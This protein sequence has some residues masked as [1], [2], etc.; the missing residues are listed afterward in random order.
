[1]LHCIVLYCIVLCCIVLFCVA[2]YCF[3]LHCFVLHC[4]VLCCIVLFCI[5]LF[6]VALYCFVLHC[7][8]LRCI[9]LICVAFYCAAL[10]CIALFCVALHCFVLHSIVLHCIALHCFVLHCILCC[11]VLHCIVLHCIVLC[12]IALR[13]IVSHCIVLHCIGLC[14]IV[15]HRRNPSLTFTDPGFWGRGRLVSQKVDADEAPVAVATTPVWAPAHLTPLPRA[16]RAAAARLGH[17]TPRTHPFVHRTLHLRT[18]DTIWRRGHHWRHKQIRKIRF[19]YSAPTRSTTQ[20][21]VTVLPVLVHNTN[22][23]TATT[24]LYCTVYFFPVCVCVCWR[25]EYIDSHLQNARRATSPASGRVS[26]TQVRL[27]SHRPTSV[28]PHSC[29]GPRLICSCLSA[30]QHSPN[31]NHGRAQAVRMAAH[32][33][34]CKLPERFGKFRNN[35]SRTATLQLPFSCCQ[36]PWPT[37]SA[38]SLFKNHT[39][40]LPL[41]FSSFTLCSQHPTPLPN[42]PPPP[43]HPTPNAVAPPS[44]GGGWGG[45]SVGKEG[46]LGGG[47]GGGGGVELRTQAADTTAKGG[48]TQSCSVWLA[49]VHTHTHSATHTYKHRQT[50]THTHTLS[51]QTYPLSHTHTHTHSATHT[52]TR[53]P[54]PHKHTLSLTHTHTHTQR[55]THTNIDRHTL[56]RTPFPHKHTLSHTH[57]HTHTLSLSHIRTSTQNVLKLIC[58]THTDSHAVCKHKLSPNTRRVNLHKEGWEALLEISLCCMWELNSTCGGMI[59]TRNCSTPQQHVPSK[60][61]LNTLKQ[62]HAVGTDTV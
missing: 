28:Q 45:L 49:S 22:S 47:S 14:C 60:F 42:T 50:H 18:G 44:P 34:R 35:C 37:S 11:I 33:R 23:I 1:M 55:H 58:D 48:P 39:P 4:I 21:D 32:G 26:G 51:S 2:L 57:T 56:T 20:W 7:I 54:F 43:P 31:H 6:C 9:A 46:M 17:M 36:T 59:P 5:A 15:S 40:L 10:Y 62:I 13:C 25:R 41:F 27:V 19:L 16:L 53:T 61:N 8:V 24:T 30:R 29:P 52:L 3:V 38:Q 12:C